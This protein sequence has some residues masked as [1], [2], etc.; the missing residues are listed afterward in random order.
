M[1]W[2]PAESCE[3]CGSRDIRL[4]ADDDPSVG[5]SSDAW[6]CRNGHNVEVWVADAPESQTQD[7]DCLSTET[8]SPAKVAGN[9]D[10]PRGQHKARKDSGKRPFPLGA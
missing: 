9:S 4:C 3:V 6:I 5:Y 8:C 10:A 1:P 2:V 7:T